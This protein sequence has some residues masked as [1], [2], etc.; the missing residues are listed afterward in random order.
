[1]RFLVDENLS[2][3]LARLLNEAG[4]DVVHVRDLGL[5]SASDAAVL[6]AARRENRT[7]VSGDTDFAALLAQAH[8]Q[9]PS[10]V[11]FRRQ[12][13]RRAAKQARLLLDNLDA[14]A[15]DLEV[16]AVVVLTDDRLRVRRLPLLPE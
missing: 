14:V 9:R 15:E 2:P 7:I 10:V 16:G 12:R 4:H 13:D 5:T 3:Q 1:V 11:L 8:L 6:E